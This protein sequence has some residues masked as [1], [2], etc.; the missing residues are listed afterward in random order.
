MR[1]QK[2]LI[3]LSSSRLRFFLFPASFA[4]PCGRASKRKCQKFSRFQSKNLKKEK[5]CLSLQQSCHDYSLACLWM[6]SKAIPEW[7]PT[8][9]K[10][11]IF[12]SFC[13][14]LNPRKTVH[15]LNKQS[16]RNVWRVIWHSGRRILQRNKCV[17][18]SHSDFHTRPQFCK[19]A[20]FWIVFSFRLRKSKHKSF[21]LRLWCQILSWGLCKNIRQIFSQQ[22][23]LEE[24]FSGFSSA[25]TA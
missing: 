17:L 10:I 15:K 8:E 16:L 5:T 20:V 9:W 23:L 24:L 19:Q 6:F 25:G 13:F 2:S 7:L 14:A 3:L 4:E 21:I 22:E 18:V 1:P 12:A 11:S